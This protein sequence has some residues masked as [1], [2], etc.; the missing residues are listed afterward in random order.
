M[1]QKQKDALTR[2][3][4]TAFPKV[5]QDLR[6]GVQND[7]V[8]QLDSLCKPIKEGT[9]LFRGTCKEE[10]FTDGERCLS[11][12]STSTDIT[13]ALLKFADTTP[14]PALWII[15][16]GKDVKGFVVPEDFN[17]E[18]E[19][20]LQRGLV[21]RKEKDDIVIEPSSTLISNIEGYELNEKVCLDKRLIIKHY[22][23][24]IV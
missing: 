20:I 1:T 24:N 16:I 7:D 5:N 8:E 3:V 18:Y 14:N 23:L 19:V 17:Q 21:I 12:I 11:Y 15:S 6:N 9:V 13:T 22:N 10:N 4:S 2:Y